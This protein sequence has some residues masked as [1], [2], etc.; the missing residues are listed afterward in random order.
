[1]SSEAITAVITGL[2]TLGVC[3]INN[4]YQIRQTT[5]KHEE[6]V[7]LISYKLD[8]LTKRVEEHNDVVVRT[9]HVEKRLEVLEE[10][11][12]VANHRI[13]DLERKS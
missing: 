12:R 7:G 6:T 8:Q 4:H 9:Y 5:Q 2:V 3:L 10:R 1:M 11:N 13:Q